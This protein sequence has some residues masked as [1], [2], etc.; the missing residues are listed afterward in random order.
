MS[1]RQVETNQHSK[2]R[3]IKKLLTDDS[4]DDIINELS[5]TK[6]HTLDL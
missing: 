5:Q 3:K 1:L 6:Q 2:K 4:L